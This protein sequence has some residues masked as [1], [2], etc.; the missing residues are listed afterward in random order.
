M[1]CCCY[2][3]QTHLRFSLNK[4]THRALVI[5][6]QAAKSKLLARVLALSLAKVV[7]LGRLLA[8]FLLE[9]LPE[10]AVVVLVRVK[11]GVNAADF[12]GVDVFVVRLESV[13]ARRVPPRLHRRLPLPLPPHLRKLEPE[14]ARHEQ[15]PKEDPHVALEKGALGVFGQVL[16][17]LRHERLRADLKQ[18]RRIHLEVERH[19]DPFL[20]LQL[21]VGP[22]QRVAQRLKAQKLG[23]A[24]TAAAAA[25][26]TGGGGGSGG[27]VGCLL[28]H[29]QAQAFG[30][31]QCGSVRPRHSERFLERRS[32]V[33]P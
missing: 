32:A 29:G 12:R 17:L 22:H 24:A 8:V 16:L 7:R 19:R 23:R 10:R 4:N 18:P 13:G 20:L 25:A 1:T 2:L 11:S 28:H 26:C 21:L 27:G 5:K 33:G 15:E 30:P 3:T 6:Q 31:R 14:P 9:L